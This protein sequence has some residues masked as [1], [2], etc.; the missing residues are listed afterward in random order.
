M[1]TQPPRPNDQRSPGDSGHRPSSLSPEALDRLCELLADDAL[2]QLPA[3]E[4]AE[5]EGL[6]ER[7]GLSVPEADPL[8]DLAA[9][10][11]GRIPMPAETRARLL[12]LGERL[13]APSAS[14]ESTAGP[15]AGRISSAAVPTRGRTFGARLAVAASVLLALGVGVLT[16]QLSELR[17]ATRAAEA[18]AGALAA[19]LQQSEQEAMRLGDSLRTREQESTRLADA[20]RDATRSLDAAQLRIA[21]LEAPIDPAEVQQN[22]RKLLEL[23]GTVR[24]AWQPFDLPDAPAEQPGVKGDVVW[25]DN[26]EQGYLRFVGLKPN[27]PKVEQY[28]IWVIDERGMEQKVSGGVFNASAEGEVIVPI[29]PA[30]DLRRVALF[31]VTIEEPGGTVVPSLKRRV[32]VAP[33]E[34]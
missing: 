21:S 1:T 10:A 18:R 9:R 22:R 12:T 23:P 33:R 28:Q 16:W 2:D 14:T 32:V 8:A 7:A 3:D 24:L 17:G 11:G 19:Q 6:L 31:A 15:I 4:R 30:I 25:N 20:L 13:M 29:D 27:D 26:L 34:G 5:F